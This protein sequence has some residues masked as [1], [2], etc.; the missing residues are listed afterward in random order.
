[1]IIFQKWVFFEILE[2]YLPTPPQKPLF[3]AFLLTN[4]QNIFKKF[5]KNSFP[6][7]SPPLAEATPW[8]GD[9]SK[10]GV[11]ST[12]KGRKKGVFLHASGVENLKSISS[13]VPSPPPPSTPKEK[14]PD[15]YQTYF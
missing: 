14:F 7:F 1:M 12:H 10:K 4:F 8:R 11:P 9:P 3:I 5:S 13:Q 6:Q 2:I 15:I